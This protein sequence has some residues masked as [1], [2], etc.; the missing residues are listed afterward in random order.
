M[1]IAHMATPGSPSQ[2]TGWISP[3]L[4]AWI[5]A[6]T[7]PLFTSYRYLQTVATT[8]I[9]VTTGAKY[10]VR[11]KFSP[12]NF[13]VTTS[14]RSNPI[15]VCRGMTTMAKKKLLTRERIKIGSAA[16]TT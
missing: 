13:W 8:T 9:E 6:F 16:R 12:R 10:M 4:A 5:I 2:L 14:A 7:S 11:K 1:I 15:A 3:K